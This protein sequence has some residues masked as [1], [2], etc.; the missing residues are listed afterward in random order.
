MTEDMIR[1]LS[2]EAEDAGVTG[3]VYDTV[4]SVAEETA[5]AVTESVGEGTDSDATVANEGASP[6]V[7]QPEQEDAGR[8]EPVT[9]LQAENEEEN[10]L[11]PGQEGVKEADSAEPEQEGVK[12]ADSAEPEQEGV[13]EADSA[14]PGQEGVKEADSIEPEQA[15]AGETVPVKT[16]HKKNKKEKPVKEKAAKAVK[17][18][19]VK[20]KAAKAV[21]E[22]PV[23]EKREKEN[24]AKSKPENAT[25]PGQ[26]K[27]G[28]GIH[29][30]LKTQLI[31]G[32]A[33]PV[34]LVAFIGIYAYNI[35]AKGM[36]KNYRDTTTQALQMTMDY[37]DF[38]F[39]SVYANAME[40]YNDTDLLNYTRGVLDPNDA[41]LLVKNYTS[42]LVAKRVGNRFIENIHIITPEGLSPITSANME[43]MKE[44]QGF[45][46]Q[47]FEQ[48][49]S[50]LKAKKR[51]EKWEYGH[52][53][54]D[55]MLKQDGDNTVLS[56]YMLTQLSNSC[57]V[58]DVS[59][60]NIMEIMQQTGLGEGSI[61]GFV[62]ADGNELLT[63]LTAEGGGEVPIADFSFI[64]Q[65]YFQAAI[66]SEEAF[67]SE[68]IKVEGTEYY[69]MAVRSQQNR[70]TLCAMI[71][72]SVMMTEANQLKS[73]VLWIA[74][75]ACIV[76]GALGVLIVIGISRNMG[77][78][79]SRLSKVARGDLTVDMTIKNKSEFG[80]LAGHIMGVVS[81]TKNL[82]A[83]TVGISKDVSVS[84]NNVSA[85][86][87][88][89]SDGTQH[90]H[91]AIEEINQGVNR[92]VEDAEQ[93]LSKM[94]ELSKVILTTEQSVVEMG[95]LADG[96]K[97]M[98]DAGSESMD[99]LI[100]HADET[101]RMTDQVDEKIAML[102]TK[103]KEIA[104]F[105]NTIN[106]ISSQ[107]TLLSLNASIEA[108]RAG[109]AGRG[110][111]V[112]AEEIKK[113]ADNSMQAA[114]EIQK[115][116]NVISE[117]TVVTRESSANAKAVVEKQSKIVEETRQ[118]FSAMNDSINK[119]LE[120]VQVI[121][122]N[123]QQ[124]SNDRGETLEAIES[125]TSVVQQTAASASL[126]NE[127]V[128]QQMDQAEA[129]R[130]VTDE[131]QNKTVEL[132]EAI[133]HFK[134]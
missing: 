1:D 91:G 123:M 132:M 101:A 84:A 11:E 58:V 108:A 78:I 34:L 61:V 79:I 111:A 8:D 85:A 5:A 75:L 92:Q 19:P 128:S 47:L 39:E 13:G 65:E 18:K 74:L 37:M 15:D 24:T 87:G 52:P 110:F 45:F 105:V 117:M 109:E 115:V 23:K 69:F 16:Q 41:A 68:D 73:T 71:P 50:V 33:L 113:L 90:I 120:N 118:N 100:E 134:V 62:T 7:V 59:A 64:G 126:V 31:I 63:G 89:L 119:L 44:K 106:E 25:K 103:S 30:S 96:T 57:I 127:T 112:V 124:M 125:I 32:F 104:T 95:H 130:E 66:E 40:L 54:I 2:K 43:T 55:E 27:K 102:A 49:E 51:E 42:V 14:E 80:T 53:L 38:G 122:E 26:E 35:A 98:I 70:A 131:L 10:P 72:R 116:V 56:L 48:H 94:D 81:N 3:E 17:E 60:E 77:N 12:E 121:Q 9:P 88:I 29:L 22:K 20:E 107:T 28:F 46:K 82:L 99:T 83:K 93:C 4:E 97:K 114:D 133:S 67:Y 129:L 21:K 76:V 6:V 86:T 36:I